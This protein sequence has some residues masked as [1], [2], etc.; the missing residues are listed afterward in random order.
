MTFH[1]KRIH[2]DAKAFTP[3]VQLLQRLLHFTQDNNAA[4]EL[5]AHRCWSCDNGAGDVYVDL[6]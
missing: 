1:A 4:K 2:A 3:E 6:I 5:P